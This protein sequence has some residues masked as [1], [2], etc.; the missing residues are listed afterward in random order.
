MST[1]QN[2]GNWSA[3]VKNDGKSPQ[4]NVHGH[5][6]TFGQKPRYHLI[7]NEPQG[8]NPSELL[9][10]LVFGELADAKG[11]IY[12]SVSY[13]E[14]MET[15]GHYKTVVVVDGNGR[16]IANIQIALANYEKFVMDDVTFEPYLEVI[17][18]IEITSNLLKIRVP[19]N[20]L[21]DKDSIQPS[22]TKG[23]TGLPPYILEVYRVK[24]DDGKAFLPEGV[25]LDY[26]PEDLKEELFTTYILEN[27]IG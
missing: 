4:I 22:I 8:I 12:F 7:K 18:G 23:F 25:V 11:S 19:S 2:I 1:N 24:P 21:T 14:L 6:P 16:T 17:K 5:F 10:T 26:T 13:T 3:I 20:G 9:L 15:H 27:R